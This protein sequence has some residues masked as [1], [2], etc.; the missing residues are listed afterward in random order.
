MSVIYTV[1]DSKGEIHTRKSSRHNRA[2]YTHAVV[3]VPGTKRKS[4]VSYSSSLRLAQ[5]SLS[6]WQKCGYVYAEICEVQAKVK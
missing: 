4:Q 1:V 6:G 2:E 5:A 3:A